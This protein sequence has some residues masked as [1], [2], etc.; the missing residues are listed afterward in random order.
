MQRTKFSFLG[1][2]VILVCLMMITTMTARAANS[3]DDDDD[4]NHG[5]LLTVDDDRVQCPDAGFTSIQA[6]VTAA[7]PGDRIN[8]CPGTYQEQIRI[9]KRLSIRGIRVSNQNL[10][11]IM[12]N[13]AVAN[14]TSFSSGLPVA[15]IVFVD[16]TAGV[17]LKNLTVDG[18]TNGINACAPTLV[19]IYYR[20]SSGKVDSV[21][22][23]NIKLGTGLEGCQSGLAI[24]A[25]SGNGGSSR[26]E[27]ANSSV[28][29]YQK[30]G[31]AGNEVGTELKAWGN[32][33][34]GIGST[35]NIAQNGI[36]I[37]FGGK[38]SIEGNSVINHIYGQCTS[39]STCTFFSANILI[40]DSNQVRIANNNTG[41][42]QINIY[43]QGN[44]GDVIGNTVFQSRVFDG[45]DLVGDRNRASGNR[46]FN[47]DASGIYVLGE[48]NEVNGNIINEAPVG[49]LEDT[50]SD[51]NHFNGNRFFNTGMNIFSFSSSAAVN[52]LVSVGAKNVS[53]ARP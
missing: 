53:P 12:P 7:S 27:V 18:A 49:I 13:P 46:V 1:M 9:N 52:A 19:G 47:S 10:A 22:V 51:D 45:I 26:L 17:N 34:S 32:A 2:L 37:A 25:Q 11:V 35:P 50:P 20:N 48:R 21:A 33:V 31:I 16:G 43:Y 30:T 28:H 3:D 42:A 5:H 39:I 29:D 14:S 4:D 44:R 6:A 15:A 38:G 24:F 36:Q 41:N 40:V 8:V 23:R